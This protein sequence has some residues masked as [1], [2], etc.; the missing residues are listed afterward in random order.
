VIKQEPQKEFQ[1]FFAHH[2]VRQLVPVGFLISFCA[3]VAHGQIAT[4]PDPQDV[5]E[6]FNESNNEVD[7]HLWGEPVADFRTPGYS[8]T[9]LGRDFSEE[10]QKN[11]SKDYEPVTVPQTSTQSAYLDLLPIFEDIQQHK[12]F[13]AAQKN[14]PLEGTQPIEHYHW[15]GLLWQSFAFFGIQNSFR[16][17]TDPFFR[18]LTADKP[19]WHDYIAS[20]RQWNMGRWS[21]GDDF[22]VAYVAHPMQGSVTEFIE[23]QNDPHDRFLEMSS[24]PAYW[25]SLFK[26]FL[27]ATAYSTDQ[28]VG[29]LSETALG[30]EGGYT[31]VIDCPAPCPSYAPGLY[32]VTNNTGWVKFI[33][34]P[35]V[36]TLWT[37]AEDFLDR[38][39]SDRVQ[40]DDL[41]AK[42]PKILRGSLNPCHTMANG[43]RGHSPWYRDYQH[44]E[45]AYSSAG[46]V[47]LERDDTES[48]RT[49]PR[50]EFFPH[51]NS[52][53]LPV[54]TSGCTACRSL[55]TGAG[56]GFSIR[57]TRWVDVDSDVDY[58][59]N[60]S[61]LPSDRAGGGAVLGTFGLRAGFAS[62]NY[63]LKASLRPGFLSYDGA[64]LTAPSTTNPTP[65]IGRITH[66]VTSL[67]IT[68]DYGIGRHFAVR[69][70]MGNTPVRYYTYRFDRP[71]GVG[72]M[73]YL[74]WISPKVF[75]TNENWTYQ[76]G[77]VL[78]F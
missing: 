68:G 23:K 74:F 78:R 7:Q 33:T 6:T 8:D 3:L 70:S 11:R 42:F 9:D 35:V 61:P 17:M 40:G 75:A 25:K 45:T 34:T 48:Y 24:D 72:T 77:P 73:P 43:L 52:I 60:A 55:T 65:E 20:L 18:Y 57:W 14:P 69:I 49:L 50:F 2:G 46:G 59:P 62:K 63:A 1:L 58:L 36:G 67:A 12:M 56:A 31:Y 5:S 37:M 32:K 4:A 10:P 39:V 26:G 54:N 30:S 38:Y 41:H 66:F 19:F 21:D 16:L 51:F 27:W 53:S 13:S 71:P 28:K 29:P 44:P 22:L 47:H 15:K 76:T 64:Y